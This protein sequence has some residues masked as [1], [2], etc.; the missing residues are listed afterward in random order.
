[1]SISAPS[2]YFRGTYGQHI[3][4]AKK[5]MNTNFK[6][7][8]SSLECQQMIFLILFWNNISNNLILDQS[9]FYCVFLGFLIL[10]YRKLSFS[11]ITFYKTIFRD[12]IKLQEFAK[13]CNALNPTYIP[14]LFSII[15]S[16]FSK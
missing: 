11:H 7:K 13:I 15:F 3:K 10:Y 12:C 4:L 6:M 9:K 8:K 5:T 2:F 16:R 14:S 1:M